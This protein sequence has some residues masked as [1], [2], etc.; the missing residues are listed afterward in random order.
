[1]TCFTLAMESIGVHITKPRQAGPATLRARQHDGRGGMQCLHG[2]SSLC[3]VLGRPGL[4]G[5]F[6]A[7]S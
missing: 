1:M 7:E 6:H 3:R 5:H 2:T 4:L